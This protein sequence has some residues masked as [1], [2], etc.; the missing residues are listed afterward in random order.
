MDNDTPFG[1]PLSHLSQHVTPLGKAGDKGAV[2]LQRRSLSVHLPERQKTA[3]DTE[4]THNN[5]K[6]KRHNVQI[7][8]T[9]TSAACVRHTHT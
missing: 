3:P 2:A 8:N 4:R 5:D 6:K 1:T 7:Q 9:Y